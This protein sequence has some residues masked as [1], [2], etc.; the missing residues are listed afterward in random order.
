MTFK[1][2]A[3][4]SG[5]MGVIKQFSIAFIALA[6]V[7]LAQAQNYP[8]RPI[9]LIVPW[10][11]GGGVDTS[12]RIIAQPLSERLGQPIVIENKPG[13]AGNIGTALAA[14]EK[15]DGYTLLMASLSPNAVN[16]HLY[17]NLGFD[18][19]KDFAPVAL[20]YTVP[21]FLVVPAASPINSA[22]ELIAAAK[23]E[24]GKL[25]FGSGGVGSSQHLFAVMLMATTGIDVTH[26]AYKGTSPS[27]AALVA[28]QVDFMLD[29]PTCLP[30]VEAGK[31]KALGVA[32]PQRNS[33]Q[34]TIP[35][36]NEL[37]IPVETLTFYGVMAPAN[38]P[39]EIV[40]RLNKE[41]NAI[42]Q[43][44]EVLSRLTKLAA[45]PGTG[46]PEDFGKFVAGELA[47]YGEIV[48]LSGAE[49]VD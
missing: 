16:P 49:K 46:S 48:K 40:D 34:P 35:T 26:V 6:C 24:P 42:L 11:A 36:L 8:S 29:V 43:T 30:F 31:L 22:K 2:T 9:R 10:P 38:T 3:T 7:G 5:I 15:P 37:G 17:K 28:G 4:H 39:K 13:A 47:R 44:P 45:D 41:I 20:A 23:A 18:P 19:V 32:S 33:A 1:K 25:N 27:E 21:S 12:A 14:Q